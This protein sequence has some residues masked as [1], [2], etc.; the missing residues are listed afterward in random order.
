MIARFWKID[1]SRHDTRSKEYNE[2]SGSFE[3]DVEMSEFAC[4][5]DVHQSGGCILCLVGQPA[6]SHVLG[7]A[8]RYAVDTDWRDQS[9]WA[10]NDNVHPSRRG[11]Y[12]GISLHLY[13]TIFVKESWRVGEPYL[14]RYTNW[15]NLHLAGRHG[16]DGSFNQDM[17]RFAISTEGSTPENLSDII[18]P[19]HFSQKLEAHNC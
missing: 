11:T 12:D 9:N 19:Q 18:L 15:K 14:S 13:E 1:K 17:Y 16:T 10:C 4:K 2:R 8:C 3:V 6:G 7:D 5:R